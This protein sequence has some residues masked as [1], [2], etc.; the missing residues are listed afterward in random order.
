MLL[1]NIIGNTIGSIAL[2]ASWD[3]CWYNKGEYQKEYDENVNKAIKMCGYFREVLNVYEAYKKTNKLSVS[4]LDLLKIA[5][6]F[7]PLIKEEKVSMENLENCKGVLET[8]LERKPIPK[9]KCERALNMLDALHNIESK[10]VWSC[11]PV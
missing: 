7:E 9:D 3:I 10:Y 4:D 11:H 6:F 1:H 2:S 5:K 8:I